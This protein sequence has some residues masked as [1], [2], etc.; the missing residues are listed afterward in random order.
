[1]R[2]LAGYV[3]ERFDL[4]LWFRFIITL[5]LL[6]MLYQ[7]M[8]TADVKIDEAFKNVLVLLVGT[9]IGYFFATSKGASDTTAVIR[10]IASTKIPTPPPPPDTTTTIK[11][12][13]KVP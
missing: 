3:I 13:T 2:E 7:A 4:T 11:T 9:A 6:Y 10:D 5:I 12:E 1:M 8:F